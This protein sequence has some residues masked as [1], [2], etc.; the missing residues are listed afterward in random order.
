MRPFEPAGG[1]SLGGRGGVG[2]ADAG[3]GCITGST[4]AAAAVDGTGP[5]LLRT[6]HQTSRANRMK[7]AVA[8]SVAMRTTTGMKMARPAKSHPRP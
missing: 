5:F 2:A 3:A 6:S 7:G 1:A 4:F 8:G